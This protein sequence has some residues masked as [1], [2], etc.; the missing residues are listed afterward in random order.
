MH[1]KNDLFAQATKIQTN[2]V[3][4]C[5]RGSCVLGSKKVI[6]GPLNCF[7]EPNK[8]WQVRGDTKKI[9]TGD[10]KSGKTIFDLERKHYPRNARQSNHRSPT[11]VRIG[12]DITYPPYSPDFSQQGGRQGSTFHQGHGGKLV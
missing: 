10:S 12:H 6:V 5:S 11:T 7:L 8:H 2:T 3:C 9:Q 4:R 1:V